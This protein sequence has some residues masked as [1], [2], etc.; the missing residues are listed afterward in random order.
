MNQKK[1][2]EKNKEVPTP[3]TKA[4]PS[5]PSSTTTSTLNATHT[6]EKKGAVEEKTQQQMEWKEK[7]LHSSIQYVHSRGRSGGFN[8]ETVLCGIPPSVQRPSYKQIV[9]SFDFNDS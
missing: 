1:K 7:K 9:N 2:G 8:S 4:L 3:E 6:E 5:P